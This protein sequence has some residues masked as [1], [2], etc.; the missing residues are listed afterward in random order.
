M[1]GKERI[2]EIHRRVEELDALLAKY[3]EP[4]PADDPRTLTTA[5]MEYF[6]DTREERRLLLEEL[7][8][9]NS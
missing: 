5:E 7:N 6:S 2:K 1:N 3:V 9:L 4:T 8:S